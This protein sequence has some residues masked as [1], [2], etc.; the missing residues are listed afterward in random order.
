[1]LYNGLLVEDPNAPPSASAIESLELELGAKLPE[2]YRDFLL[3]CN[4]GFVQYEFSCILGDGSN[5]LV[6][7]PSF[8]QLDPNP[9]FESNPLTLREFRSLGLIPETLVLPIA[10]D[11]GGTGGSKI[12]LDL[13]DGYRI[14]GILDDVEF[15]PPLDEPFVEI[16]K[17][18]SAYWKMLHLSDEFVSLLVTKTAKDDDIDYLIQWLDTGAPGWRAKYGK[19]F[20]KRFGPR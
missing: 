8:Y 10:H 9:S 11:G 4:G 13:R 16:A 20:D 2:D 15:N 17:D 5:H 19:R 12:F 7:I 18:F 14:V 1:M 3:T 6:E